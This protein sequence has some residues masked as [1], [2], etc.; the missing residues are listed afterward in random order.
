MPGA[1]QQQMSYAY[2][3][4]WGMGVSLKYQWQQLETRRTIPRCGAGAAINSV[5]PKP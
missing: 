4:V 1:K 3:R 5:V 2:V